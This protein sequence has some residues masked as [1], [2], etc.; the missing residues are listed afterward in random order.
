MNSFYF[1]LNIAEMADGRQPEEDRGLPP[2]GATFPHSTF[3]NNL[4]ATNVNGN[5]EPNA[6]S[7]AG[8]YNGGTSEP[9]LP[10]YNIGFQDWTD[11]PSYAADTFTTQGS[12][13]TDGNFHENLDFL[14][15]LNQPEA[16][17]GPNKPYAANYATAVDGLSLNLDFMQASDSGRQLYEDAARQLNQSPP[18]V[19]SPATCYTGRTYDPFGTTEVFPTVESVMHQQVPQTNESTIPETMGPTFLET[20]VVAPPTVVQPPARV[21]P[22][23]SEVAKHKVKSSDGTVKRD[24]GQTKVTPPMPVS[25][26]ASG[27]KNKKSSKSSRSSRHHSV[28]MDRVVIRPNSRYGL[29]TFEDPSEVQKDK[30]Q[31]RVCSS[32]GS[33]RKGSCSSIGSGVDDMGLEKP[34][35]QPINAYDIHGPGPGVGLKYHSKLGDIVQDRSSKQKDTNDMKHCKGQ[36]KKSK[37]A[38]KQA[39][40]KTF[41]DPKRIFNDKEKKSASHNNNFIPNNQHNLHSE[42][43]ETSLNSGKAAKSDWKTVSSN[44]INNDLRDAKKLTNTEARNLAG[45]HVESPH[46]EEEKSGGC[47][48]KGKR[49]E[50]NS[51]NNTGIKKGLSSAEV[52]KQTVKKTKKEKSI[53]ANHLLGKQSFFEC[54]NFI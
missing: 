28:P 22:S 30:L 7:W 26:S 27:V 12:L 45:S 41:F 32:S 19:G 49:S 13:P 50:H 17:S 20:M 23:Y 9:N 6:F 3:Y 40:A 43:V 34:S 33:S 29:D 25:G 4:M 54:S 31:G 18:L 16:L 46:E 42:D 15:S 21:K 37:N 24:T 2:L 1:L 11:F 47:S 44:Y 10:G 8:G 5:G 53:H 39:S 51:N 48:T 52:V 14:T 38:A 36:D 35:I